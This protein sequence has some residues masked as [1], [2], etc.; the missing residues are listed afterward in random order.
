MKQLEHKEQCALIDWWRLTHKQ[1]GLPEFALFAIPNGGKRNITTA[2]RLKREGV[3][4]GVADLMLAMPSDVY[5]GLFIE[6]KAGKNKT[7]ETQNTF[8]DYAQ[9]YGYRACVC[10]GWEDAAQK[11][12]NYLGLER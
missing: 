6:M 11:I 5:S 9:K 10:Y 2:V 3:R 12:R 4:A 7:T 8:L 1:Y